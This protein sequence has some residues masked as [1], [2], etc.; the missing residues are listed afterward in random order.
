MLKLFADCFCKC[1]LAASSVTAWD[2]FSAIAADAVAA[3]VA[4][5]AAA[6]GNGNGKGDGGGGG[7]ASEI[8]RCEPCGGG[9][10]GVCFGG[11][12]AGAG[13]AGATGRR[14]NW[15]PKAADGRMWVRCGGQWD[16]PRGR[17]TEKSE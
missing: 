11:V 10:V 6:A 16:N 3:A 2:H 9:R 15:F 1:V 7:G 12:S 4:A 8:P 14:G 13:T 5:A 17:R